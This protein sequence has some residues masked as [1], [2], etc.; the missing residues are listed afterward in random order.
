L[1]GFERLDVALRLAAAVICPGG[2]ELNE[3]DAWAIVRS[4]LIEAVKRKGGKQPLVAK[5]V[6]DLGDAKASDYFRQ[7]EARYILISS[8]SVQSL[9]FR[10]TQV[11]GCQI[12]SLRSRRTFPYPQSV[13]NTGNDAI[14]SHIDSP[15]YQCVRVNTNG[16]SIY[17]AAEKSFRALHLLRGM[18]SLFATYGSWT[19]SFGGT[20]QEPI[21]VI[22]AGP[23]HTLHHP[24][25]TL[26]ADMFWYERAATNDRKLFKPDKGWEQIE[27]H[28][29]WAMKRMRHLNYRKDLEDL[30]LRY[31]AA[32]DQTDHNVALL[33]MWSILE[34]VTNTVGSQY[35]ETVRRTVWP[36]KSRDI[37]KNLLDCVRLQRNLY[38]HAARPAE[39]PDQVTYLIKSFVDPHLVGL[40]RGD[41]GVTSLEEYGQHLSLPTDIPTLVRTKKWVTKAIRILG[42]KVTGE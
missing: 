16:K 28:R 27:K 22:H 1:W 33:Q 31:V 20:K 38:V 2:E 40:I 19:I 8:L 11:A 21:G 37:E 14:A 41:F 15:R 9:P 23:V 36:F 12:E 26:V 7:R 30:I 24:D 18:W 29:R 42:Q 25:H 13:R 35:D 10:R 4:T 6:L 17:D 39:E 3:Q 5:E 34:K 32:L